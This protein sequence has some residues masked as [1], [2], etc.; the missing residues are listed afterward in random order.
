M[1]KQEMTYIFAQMMLAWPSAPMFGGGI[2]K[3]GPTIML[4]TAAL[5][6]VD[7]WTGKQAV[8]QVCRDCSFPP[9]IAE[10]RKAA[11]KVKADISSRAQNAFLMM[12]SCLGLYDENPQEYY[13]R[14]PDG[15]TE[16][17]AIQML[18]GPD[19]LFK[20]GL[21]QREEYIAA[22]EAVLRRVDALPH[23]GK[24]ITQP[25]TKRQLGGGK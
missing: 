23:V 19:A 17:A 2:Q 18:G 22:Y 3:L 9:N 15:S 4:W 13:S 21:W 6:D 16:K 5:P 1:T 25:E 7:F 8:V 20:S 14:L 11:D 24:Q 12:Q 10:F